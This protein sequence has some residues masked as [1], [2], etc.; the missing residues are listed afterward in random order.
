MPDEAY[1]EHVHRKEVDLE[2]QVRAGA[3]AGAARG[4]ADSPFRK[5]GLG[6]VVEGGKAVYGKRHAIRLQHRQ[7]HFY[8]LVPMVL[9]GGGSTMNNDYADDESSM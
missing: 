5:G 1:L 8:Q 6:L 2:E 9:Y 7:R 4:G 3:F